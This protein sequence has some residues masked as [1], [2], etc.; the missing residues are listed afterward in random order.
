MTTFNQLVTNIADELDRTDADTIA[1]IPNMIAYAE[2]L[3]ANKINNLGL[4]QYIQGLLVPGNPVMAKPARWRTHITFSY[5][6]GVGNTTFNQ[7]QLRRYEYMVNYWPD[8]TQTAAPLFYGDYGYDHILI[9]PTPD[10]AYPYEWGYLELPQP[11]S[12]INQTNWYTDHAATLLFYGALLN[13]S[14][15]LRDPERYPEWK[16]YFEEHLAAINARDGSRK[17]DRNVDKDAD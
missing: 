6:S 10:Q 5:G 4:V 14:G 3:L 9:S 7:M 16:A 15:F 11:L 12:V 13:T 1:A 2:D 8:R 17:V